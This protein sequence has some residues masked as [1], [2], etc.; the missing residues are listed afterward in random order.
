MMSDISSMMVRNSHKYLETDVV[1][2]SFRYLSL[3]RRVWSSKT[4]SCPSEF[5]KS[6]EVSGAVPVFTLWNHHTAA[7]FFRYVWGNYILLF[8]V[9]AGFPSWHKFRYFSTVYSHVLTVRKSIQQSYVS[10][11][12][13]LILSKAPLFPESWF[14]MDRRKLAMLPVKIANLS[15]WY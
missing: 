8:R 4:N 13:G 10:G 15:A 1:C 9:R 5:R 7:M 2:F 11:L 3:T 12:L 6:V 14:I